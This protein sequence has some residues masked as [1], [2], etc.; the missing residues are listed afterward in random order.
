MVSQVI[1][2]SRV[3]GANILAIYQRELQGY[4]ASPLAYGVASVFWLIAGIFFV[5]VL[6]GDSGIIAQSAARDMQ[7]AQ[8]GIPVPP[9]DVPYEFLKI[10]LGTIGSLALFVLP[11]LS[12][13]LYT[14]ERKRGTLELLATSPITNWAV[15]VG[16]LLGVATFFAT[17]LAPLL[18][19][20]IIVLSAASPALSPWV[21]VSGHV[22]LV[23]MG[24]SVL[25]LGMFLS[26]LTASTVL[27]AMMTFGLNLSL[28]IIDLLAN[29]IG[30]DAGQLVGHLSLLK[31]Y[32]AAVRGV[33]ESGSVVL[34]FSYIILGIFLTAQSVETFRFQRS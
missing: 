22:G 11:I 17:M 28:W 8:M 1:Y 4:F 12:M 24:T 18:L 33:P 23:L 20:E 26:S 14:E 5:A 2:R 3:I 19:M 30:G 9:I 15:A 6:L 29:A 31:H 21:A 7:G 32:E 27:A 25:S 16:K 13:S 10:Y 34:F